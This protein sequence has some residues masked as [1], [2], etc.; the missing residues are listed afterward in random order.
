MA[1]KYWEVL[2]EENVL[3]P[4][5]ELAKDRLE[6]YLPKEDAGVAYAELGYRDGLDD[7]FELSCASVLSGI[8][9]PLL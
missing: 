8:H 1:E 4:T 5:R 2:P 6:T 7:P 3:S 9:V